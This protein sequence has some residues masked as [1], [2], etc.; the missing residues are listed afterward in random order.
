MAAS[1]GSSTSAAARQGGDQ[2]SQV[3]PIV[4]ADKDE[5]NKSRLRA[6]TTTVCP[7]R[8]MRWTRGKWTG[9]VALVRHAVAYRDP[10]EEVTGPPWSR[11]PR[12]RLPHHH[13]VPDKWP[14]NRGTLEPTQRIEEPLRT[15]SD[16]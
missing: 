15:G 8:V 10:T 4:A 6:M 13:V 14:T 1:N 16:Q 3:W 9:D 11:H 5:L 12:E 7:R 2:P